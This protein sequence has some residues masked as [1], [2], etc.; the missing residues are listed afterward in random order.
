M[1]GENRPLL[2]DDR[3]EVKKELVEVH[4]DFGENYRSFQRNLEN[5]PQVNY[6]EPKDH[7]M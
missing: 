5:I 4:Q 3:V 6:E 1:N 2:T 7:N